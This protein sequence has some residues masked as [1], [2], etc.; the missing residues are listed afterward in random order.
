[1]CRL[2]A[3][4]PRLALSISTGRNWAFWAWCTFWLFLA[5]VSFPRPFRR[6]EALV[7]CCNKTL[8]T[9]GAAGYLANMKMRSL[10]MQMPGNRKA[11]CEMRIGNRT[12]P[13]SHWEFVPSQAWWDKHMFKEPK[14]IY[15]ILILFPVFVFVYSTDKPSVS[16]LLLNYSFLIPDLQSF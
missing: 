8:L 9:A 5:G 7:N 12:I 4:W 11:K 15:Y 16:R 10:C 13:Y 2:G 14:W 6:T 3:N 1:M